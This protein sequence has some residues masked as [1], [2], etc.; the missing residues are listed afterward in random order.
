[1]RAPSEAA[2]PLYCW[3]RGDIYGTDSSDASHYT[4]LSRPDNQILTRKITIYYL[5]RV[6]GASRPAVNKQDVV[7]LHAYRGAQRPQ[8]SG[9]FIVLLGQGAYLFL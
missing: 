8:R 3:G 7:L 9:K 1:M 4:T 5:V 2:S 6:M